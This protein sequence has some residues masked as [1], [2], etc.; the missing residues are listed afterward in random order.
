MN[1]IIALLRGINV[2]GRNKLPMRELTQLLESLGLE[3]VKTYIQS[4]NVVFQ[5]R[6]DDLPAL[7]EE[8]GTAIQDSHGF[9]PRVLL[10]E[11]ADLETAVA[12]NRY[13]TPQ[14][15]LKRSTSISWNLRRLTPIWLR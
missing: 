12:Q 4:G 8:I 10:L 3:N 9:T 14:K 11:L 1:T 13:P 2:G 15:N 5:G 6:R 7:A